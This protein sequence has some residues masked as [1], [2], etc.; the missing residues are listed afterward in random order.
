MGKLIGMRSCSGFQDLKLGSIV[1]CHYA[2]GLSFLALILL[3][4]RL[5]N[6]D[7]QVSLFNTIASVWLP[8]TLFSPSP[9]NDDS[10]EAIQPDAPEE[11]SSVQISNHTSEE[12]SVFITKL[13]ILSNLK[14][15][16][17][18][19]VLELSSARVTLILSI[20]FVLVY[21]LSW[22]WMAFSINQA[23]EGYVM[24]DRFYPWNMRAPSAVAETDSIAGHAVLHLLTIQSSCATNDIMVAIVVGF[25]TGLRIYSVAC[26][27]SYYKKAKKGIMDS[28]QKSS[29]DDS[30]NISEKMVRL[31]RLKKMEN[32]ARQ[33]RG[34]IFMSSCL[35]ITSETEVVPI[36]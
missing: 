33:N 31:E 14:S 9:P 1:V 26:V 20:V 13:E 16:I 28:V 18:H 35:D 21:I 7:R 23:R 25:L 17:E 29:S 32:S 30:E 34:V 27:Y 11:T 12:T 36:I 24:R 19:I 5:Y 3:V 8:D 4:G 22:W 2:M 10:N 6:V 15:D